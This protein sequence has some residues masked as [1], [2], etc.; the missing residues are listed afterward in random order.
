MTH[1][2]EKLGLSLAGLLCRFLGELQVQRALNH[3]LLELMPVSVKFLPDTFFLRDVLVYRYKVRDLTTG[4][5]Q[6]RD[7]RKN[8]VFVPLLVPIE[9]LTFPGFACT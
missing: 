9:K 2:G 4:V 7:D 8:V 3:E 1:V 6:G 5:R